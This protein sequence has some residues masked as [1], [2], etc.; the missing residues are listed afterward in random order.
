MPKYK[1][2]NDMKLI[3]EVVQPDHDKP[4][5]RLNDPPAIPEVGDLTIGPEGKLL[6]VVQ[7]AFFLE[8]SE[9]TLVVVSKTKPAP[10]LVF[11]CVVVPADMAQ[12]VD[13][14]DVELSTNEVLH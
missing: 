12:A 5:L 8:D 9:S 2:E 3:L 14:D 7:R 4:L 11:Q 6:R 13:V 1:G 10:I